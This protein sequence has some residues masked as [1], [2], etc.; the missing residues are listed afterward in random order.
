MKEEYLHYLFRMKLLGNTFITVTGE[1]LEIINFGRYNLNAGPDFLE[2]QIRFDNKLWSGHIEFH[3]N[4]S[5]WFLHHHENDRA[6]DNVIAHFVY[7]ADEEV[8]INNFNVPTVEL[9][10]LVDEN[11]FKAYHKLIHSKQSIP[12]KN[13]VAEVD[14]FFILQQK[15]RALINRLQKK[16]DQILSELNRYNG[17]LEWTFFVFL[18]RV[19]GGKVNQLPFADLLEKTNLG[20]FKKNANNQIV[21]DA[22]LFGIA[23]LLP[24]QHNHKY[25]QDLIKEFDFQKNKHCL[26]I[27][28][29]LQWRFSKMRPHGFPPIRIAQLSSLLSKNLNVSALLLEE[30][31]RNAIKKLFLVDLADFW[32]THYRF[33]NETKLKSIALSADFIDLICINVIVPFKFA[34]GVLNDDEKLK[35]SALNLLTSLKPEKNTIIDSWKKIGIKCQ[36]AFDSQA[37]IE[38]NN[39]YCLEKKCLFCTIGTK[40]LQS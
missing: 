7:S 24:K 21:I 12:C 25:V 16:S 27:M 9:K 33:E 39:H 37:L 2:G 4:A 40:L 28:Q 10:K 6:Y 36:S 14:D 15:E 17:D 38:Q 5:D 31:N 11:P 1:S 29:P 35:N 8:V 22:V 13:N 30:L 18:A 32:N 19:F 34:L 20:T 3:V 23:G 26:T